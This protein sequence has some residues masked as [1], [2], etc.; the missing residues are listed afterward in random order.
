MSD[1]TE[2]TSDELGSAEHLPRVRPQQP[3][4]AHVAAPAHAAAVPETEPASTPAH[5][6]HATPA[7]AAAPAPATMPA[8]SPAPDTAPQDAPAAQQDATPAPEP[9]SSAEVQHQAALTPA[10]APAAAPAPTPS[11][12]PAPEVAPDPETTGPLPIEAQMAAG[13]WQMPPAAIDLD[14]R[15]DADVEIGNDTRLSWAARTDV[16]LVRSHN[17]DSYLARNPLF[18]VC[19]GMGGHAAGEVASSIAVQ[20]IAAHA[21]TAADD[22]L[23]GAAVE[24]ANEAVIEGA[25][26]GTGK[27][28]MG[29][30]ASCCII[31]GT[32]MA[33]AHVGDSRIYLLRSGTLVRVT[34]DHSYVEELVDAGEIT[35]DEARVHPSRSII[36]RALGSDPDMYADHFMLDVERGDRI[37]VCSDGLSS[38]IPDSAIESIAVSSATPIDCVDALVSATLS[39]GAHD[40]VTVIVVDVVS[41][42]RE[43]Q[44]RRARNRAVIGWL[45][46]VLAVVAVVVGAL[47]LIVN[48]SWYVGTFAGNVAIYQGVR[49][50]ILGLPLSQLDTAT[51]VSVSNLPEATQHQL[52]S[53]ITV[54]SEADAK[55]TVQAYESQI[56][57][58]RSKASAVASGAQSESQDGAVG[59]AGGAAGPDAATTGAAT[60]QATSA[61]ATDA[62]AQTTGGGE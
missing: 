42:G 46:G 51:Q 57:E 10:P 1:E 12:A 30:T 8:A 60:N 43:E 23:L 59:D 55:A 40:N 54:A 62:Q 61:A 28:G 15:P 2:N 20:A 19:D 6:A 11:P 44:R 4:G 41:D 27:P 58:E 32:H 48:K 25:V 33:V 34:H 9:A 3:T 39:E 29:C 47:A 36:T 14:A 18:G 35:A 21:P 52:A 7:A 56:Q 50:S 53:G 5:A 16:G 49:S 26:N 31:E 24:A 45:V 22:A 17:E 38:M 13:G 37:V